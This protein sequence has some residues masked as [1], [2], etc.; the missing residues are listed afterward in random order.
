LVALTC[1]MI[2][3]PF[4]GAEAAQTGW[5]LV[6][7]GGLPSAAPASEILGPVEYRFLCAW[8]KYLDHAQLP[9]YDPENPAELQ[10]QLDMSAIC[11]KVGPPPAP[12]GGG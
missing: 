12:P 2:L 4:P 1:Q 3:A 11:C 9:A 6:G 7:S 8:E 5:A 10:L